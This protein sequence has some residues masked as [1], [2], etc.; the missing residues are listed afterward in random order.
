MEGSKEKHM[1]W[2]IRGLLWIL[3]LG[4]QTSGAWSASESDIAAF[5]T[6]IQGRLKEARYMEDE[7]KSISLAGWE[8][9]PTLKCRYHVTEKGGTKKPGLVI[10][11]NPSPE[12]LAAWILNACEAVKPTTNQRACAQDVFEH[13]LDQS[14]GQFPVSGVV[15]EDIIPHNGVFEAYGFHNGVTTRLSELKHRRTKPL[16]D[17]ELETIL[18][19]APLHTITLAAP[20]RIIGVTR[21]TYKKAHPSIH[22]DGL[23]WNDVVAGE[24]KRALSGDRNVLIE[25]WLATPTP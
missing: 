19:A 21:E 9:L 1:V 2:S 25:A 12:R 17:V 20:A 6:S 18:D 23:K 8:N 22:I 10:M 7:C 3:V 15:Y 24:Q 4:F 16:D 13:I 5:A 11:A 14:G